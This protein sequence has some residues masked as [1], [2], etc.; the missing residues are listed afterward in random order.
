MKYRFF[1]LF[2]AIEILVIWIAQN[3]TYSMMPLFFILL[4]L[5]SGVILWV[6]SKY[7]YIPL[8]NISWGLLYS[9]TLVFFA[10]IGF[11]VYIMFLFHSISN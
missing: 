11:L 1:L 9:S 5:F 6:L 10:G 7:G 8:K 4:F 3:S 2:L